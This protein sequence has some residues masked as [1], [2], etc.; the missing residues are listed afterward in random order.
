MIDFGDVSIGDPDYDLAFL[1]HRLGSTFVVNLL[2]YLPHDDPARL[3]KKI[4]G[5]VRFNAIEDVLIGLDRGD[6]LLI[7][8]ALAEL[9]AL[10]RSREAEPRG[11][12]RP[13]SDT[14]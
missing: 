9:N 14:K 3:F 2:R 6:R 5:F 10:A 12:P 4:R 8:L 11:Q 7:D 13:V 1:G